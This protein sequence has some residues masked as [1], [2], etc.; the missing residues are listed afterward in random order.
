M[1]KIGGGFNFFFDGLYESWGWFSSV[2]SGFKKFSEGLFFTKYLEVG[3][4]GLDFPEQF[5]FFGLSEA[6]I[7]EDVDFFCQF[8]D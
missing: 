7:Q 6:I 1:A 2:Y 8:L 4:V 5:V 3:R